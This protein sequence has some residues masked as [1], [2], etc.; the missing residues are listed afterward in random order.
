MKNLIERRMGR[1]VISKL[2]MVEAYEAFKQ[3]GL[4]PLRT[5]HVYC[6]NEFEITGVSYHF[7]DVPL[8]EMVPRYDIEMVFD[9]NG[10]VEYKFVEDKSIKSQ[11]E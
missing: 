6:S 1:L 2:M 8:G 11:G 9:D 7:H 10:D 4:F 3:L 5:E